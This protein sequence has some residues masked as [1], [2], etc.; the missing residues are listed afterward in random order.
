[1]YIILVIKNDYLEQNIKIMW[2][3]L[4]CMVNMFAMP[5]Y[6]YFYIWRKTPPVATLP[7]PSQEIS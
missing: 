5:F 6:W 4:I 1:L 3:I 7:K 2:V